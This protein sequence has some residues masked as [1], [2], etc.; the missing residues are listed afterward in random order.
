MAITNGWIDLEE[1]QPSRDTFIV[2]MLPVET[3][4]ETESG[5]IISTRDDSVVEDRPNFGEIVAV[6]PESKRK[7]HEFVYVQKAM[8]YDLKMIRTPKDCDTCAYVLLYEEAIIGNR[9]PKGK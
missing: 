6:G 4:K 1:F 3:K 9:I 8:G 7:I 2:K 5:L